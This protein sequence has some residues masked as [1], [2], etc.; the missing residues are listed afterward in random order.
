MELGIG[1]A[2]KAAELGAV[3]DRFTLETHPRE[4][5]VA[6]EESSAKPWPHENAGVTV[7]RSRFDDA[8]KL[9]RRDALVLGVDLVADV[10]VNQ[11][12]LELWRCPLCHEHA[13]TLGVLSDTRWRGDAR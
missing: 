1:E 4:G 6:I 13:V 7:S 12:S 11:R 2:G 10:E 5:G 9:R 8:C 3:E